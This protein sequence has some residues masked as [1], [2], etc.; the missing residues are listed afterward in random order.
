[1][2]Q[3][4]G[5]K[6]HQAIWGRAQFRTQC[7]QGLPTCGPSWVASADSKSQ[8]QL[9]PG[10]LESNMLRKKPENLPELQSLAR[11][12]ARTHTSRHSHLSTHRQV[13]MAMARTHTAKTRHTT[14][15]THLHLHMH[16]AMHTRTCM[17]LQCTHAL[18][19][20]PLARHAGQPCAPIHCSDNHVLQYTPCLRTCI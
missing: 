16:L 4:L 14:S 11:P 10:C 13:G 20:V 5:P 12:H 18:P 9:P 3:L 6:G 1:M 19:G 15:T 8:V 2:L 17:H 7:C